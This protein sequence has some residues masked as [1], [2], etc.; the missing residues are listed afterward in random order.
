MRTQITRKTITECSIYDL[1]REIREHEN[2]GWK[3]DGNQYSSQ[4]CTGL[5]GNFDTYYHQPMVLEEKIPDIDDII[6]AQLTAEK[7]RREKREWGDKLW[8]MTKDW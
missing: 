5:F 7:K 3:R 4:I 2:K 6:A 8:E 1:E